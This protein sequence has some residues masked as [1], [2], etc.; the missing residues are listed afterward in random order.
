MFNEECGDRKHMTCTTYIYEA[1]RNDWQEEVTELSVTV[2]D[3]FSAPG[4]TKRS[5]HIERFSLS[6]EKRFR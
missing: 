4:Y 5:F 1:C 3:N 6:L 2:T